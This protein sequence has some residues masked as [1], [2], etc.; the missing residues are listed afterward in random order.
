VQVSWRLRR[1]FEQVALEVGVLQERSQPDEP[2]DDHAVA[3]RAHRRVLPLHERT[4]QPRARREREHARPPLRL[5]RAHGGGGLD[6]VRAGVGEA[7]RQYD[8]VLERAAGALPE[9]GRHGMPRV[10][11]QHHPAAPR[12]GRG[13][14]GPEPPVHQRRPHHGALGRAAHHRQE[15]RRPAA[16]ELQRL[17]LERHGVGDLRPC[18]VPTTLYLRV[19]FLCGGGGLSIR[20][21]CYLDLVC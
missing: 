11:G 4:H 20:A 3:G 5:V 1:R 9:V 12:R 17:A 7:A 15:V 13:Q 21:I 16:D 19:F 10:A 18:Q 14:P 8:G 6:P 2:G